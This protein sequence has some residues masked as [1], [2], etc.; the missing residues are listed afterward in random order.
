MKK[1]VLHSVQHSLVKILFFATL[2]QTIHAQ[3]P[4]PATWNSFIN[5]AGNVFVSDTFRLQTF[6]DNEKDN[7]NFSL[8]GG[9][10]VVTDKSTLKITLGSNVSFESISLAGYSD[11]VIGLRMAGKYLMPTENLVFKCF[12]K[13]QMETL[14]VFAPDKAET[15][16]SYNLKR[17]V[18]NPSLVHIIASPPASNTK[19]GYYMTDAVFALG[20]IPHY[21]LFIG[22]GNWNDT[23]RWSH[24]PPLRNRSA[25]I[26]GDLTIGTDIRC[27]STALNA[28]SLQLVSNAR[29]ATDNLHLHEADASLTS[30]GEIVINERIIFHKTFGEKGKWYFISFPFN[31]YPNNIDTRFQ[32][33][34]EAPNSGGNYFYVQRYNGERR[35]QTNSPTGNWE[36]LP[37][38]P[39]NS[40]TP[41]FEKNKGYLIALDEKA[42]SRTLTFASK[43]G[44][45]PTDFAKNG[46][47]PVD[48]P[49]ADGSADKENEGWYL[50]GNPMPAPL[51][52]A[53]IEANPALDGYLYLYEGNR[54]KAYPITGN[55][56]IPPLAAFFVKSS[57]PTQLKIKYASPPKRNIVLQTTFPLLPLAGEPCAEANT[58]TV[59]SPIP[60][61]AKSYVKDG[62]IYLENIQENGSVEVFDMMGHCLLRQSIHSTSETIQLKFRQGL[63]IVNIKAGR[64]E[65]QHKIVL[66]R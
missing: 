58:S 45:I 1:N 33:K 30:Q 28:G 27:K 37:I 24:L 63:Y 57:S 36:V 43:P 54:Y 23:T 5:S 14:T 15:T 32:Q 11:V 9:A 10:T 41:L 51:Q 31:V 35:S 21:S 22:T 46:V 55:Y 20:N 59:L 13:Q 38:K 4:D 62:T 8:Q 61:T 65:A 17:I 18:D 25:L 52:F 26:S 40:S 44:E 12:R 47:V 50:C 48:A 56:A 3:A 19:S 39:A 6:G 66:Y 53:D 42:T 2:F 7:W 64:F 29:F 60:E 49:V 16:Y 34:D